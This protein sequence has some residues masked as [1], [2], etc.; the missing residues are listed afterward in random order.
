MSLHVVQLNPANAT[1]PRYQRRGESFDKFDW[2]LN[3][4]LL[5]LN[6]LRTTPRYCPELA[7][8]PLFSK[9]TWDSS[10]IG[11]NGDEVRPRKRE[12]RRGEK[13]IRMYTRAQTFIKRESAYR[14]LIVLIY[15]ACPPSRPPA[16]VFPVP[17]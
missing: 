17:R 11:A 6:A 16:P 3:I 7:A 5:L 15:L 4:K 13:K 14:A 1:R 8:A 9:K 10:F 12:R 2:I